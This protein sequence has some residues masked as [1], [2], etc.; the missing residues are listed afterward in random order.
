MMFLLPKKKIPFLLFCIVCFGGCNPEK[1]DDRATLATAIEKSITTE[2]LNKWYP[3]VIDKEYGGFLSTFTFDFKP[4]GE[5]DK[6]IVS[7]SRHIWTTSKAAE[8]YP[9]NADY[10][11]CADHGFKFLRDVM[12]DKTYGGFHTLVDRQGNVKSGPNEEKTAYGNAFAIYALAAYYHAF[13]DTS[14]LKLAQNG[15]MWLEK[16][17]H[18]PVYK[19]YFQHMKRDGTVIKRD[20][21]VQSTQDI[22]YKDQNSSIHLLEAFTELYTVWPDDL[23]GERVKEMLALIRDTIVTDKGNLT[24]FLL[25]DWTPVSFR[26][27]SEAVIMKHH[28]LDH[29]S[30][31][32][33]VETAYLM[34]EASH[35]VG[36]K[37]NEKTDAIGKKMVDHALDTG[38]DNEVG[39]FY[40]EGYYFK[41]KPG[42][43]II[44]DTK[45][46]WAQAEGL[47][48]LLIMADQYPDDD[49]QYYEKFKTMWAYINT[50]LIDHEHGEWYQGGL[51]KE[52]QQKTALK[53]HIWKASYHQYRAL[54]NCAQ[55]LKKKN[56][57]H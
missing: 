39:G 26:D 4:T 1:T 33:D 40:D 50:N 27:S 6:M 43:T 7:Q 49:H 9:Q 10:K 48:T 22:G 31:G 20:N 51:D 30:F 12:W 15:F 23:V 56:A 38:W 55:R 45:N 28:N 8:T 32:H 44:R 42:M 14:A 53:G 5:Q 29:V 11:T 47:N 34:Q 57:E 2:L 35:V 19:G 16:N 36:L 41:D 24:L 46:W 17:S 21:N 25:P 3:V 13:G 52:P 37:D 18:D 54:A